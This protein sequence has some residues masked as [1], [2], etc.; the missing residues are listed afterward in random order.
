[1][2]NPVLRI[3]KGRDKAIQA[4]SIPSK[5]VVQALTE[6]NERLVAIEKKIGVKTQ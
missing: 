1:M 3:E 2:S 4:E 5:K 6:I